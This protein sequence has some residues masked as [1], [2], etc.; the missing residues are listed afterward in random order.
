V[1]I[2]DP[3]RKYYQPYWVPVEKLMDAI[4]TTDSGTS[5]PRGLVVVSH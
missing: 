2:L 1:L 5:R 3:D 4:N